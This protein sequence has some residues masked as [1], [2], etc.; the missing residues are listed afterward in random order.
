YGNTDHI[1]VLNQDTTGIEKVQLS[2]DLFLTDSDINLLIQQMTAYANSNG[3]SLTTV[4]DVKN[5]QELMGM[6]VSAWHQ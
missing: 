4:D 6:V 1:T 5:N 3:I 2:N